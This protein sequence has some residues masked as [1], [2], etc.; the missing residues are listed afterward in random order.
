MLVAVI[1]NRA[2]DRRFRLWLRCLSR[3]IGTPGLG[4]MRP[5][6]QSYPLDILAEYALLASIIKLGRSTVRVIGNILRGLEYSPFF[7][8]ARKTGR[9]KRMSKRPQ[10]YFAKA[11]SL[12]VPSSLELLFLTSSLQVLDR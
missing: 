8:K 11:A 2:L 3:S 6:F 10:S 7:K 1:S 12:Q 5:H 4:V 9:T